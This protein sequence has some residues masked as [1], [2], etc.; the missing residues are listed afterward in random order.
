MWQN[1]SCWTITLTANLKACSQMKNIW[2]R[3][4]MQRPDFLKQCTV[5]PSPK[6]GNIFNYKGDSEVVMDPH[7]RFTSCFTGLRYWCYGRVFFFSHPGHRDIL[8]EVNLI[9]SVNKKNAR[10]FPQGNIA[11]EKGVTHR[12]TRHIK[13]KGY[14]AE[15]NA[16]SRLLDAGTKQLQKL[17]FTS[18]L[19]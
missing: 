10:T 16:L 13:S 14:P 11:L 17:E 8:G 12:D 2:R 7:N 1:D 9:A 15:L 6:K 18:S 4:W 19:Q 5:T 3:S